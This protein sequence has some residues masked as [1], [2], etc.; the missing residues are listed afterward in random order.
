[1]V[2]RHIV[3]LD[4]DFVKGD[5]WASVESILGFG[6]VMYSTHSHCPAKPRLRLVIPLK[7][8]TTDEYQATR[9]IAADIGIDFFDDTT[10]QPHRLMYWPSTSSDGEYV[11]KI[12]DEP[13][14]DRIRLLQDTLTG[15]TRL[16][17]QKALRLKPKEKA[18]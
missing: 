15:Q 4:A 12:L 6:C 1:M 9:R 2:W 7:A 3:T 17:G 5:L 18:G 8:V 10:Y 14:V 16:T 11:F 13:W